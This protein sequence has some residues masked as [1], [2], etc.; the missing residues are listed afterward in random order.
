MTNQP[1]HPSLP[2]LVE[3]LKLGKTRKHMFLCTRGKCSSITQANESWE[4]LKKR[5]R[6][7]GLMDVEGGVYRSPADCLRV[8][9][10]G[11]IMV[12]YPEGVWYHSCTP[13]VIELILQQHILRDKIVADYCLAQTSS[14][15]E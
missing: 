13:E 7:L 15:A 6:E 5:I 14:A 1:L 11:P 4:Y 2:V 8:C 10:Q 12:I 9:V 3:N